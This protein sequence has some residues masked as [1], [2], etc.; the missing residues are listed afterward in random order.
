M[1]K[2]EVGLSKFI[3]FTIK[4]GPAKLSVVRSFKEQE[5]NEYSPAID[6]W[7]QLRTGIVEMHKKR[8]PFSYLDHIVDKVTDNKKSQYRTA[9]NQYKKIFQKKEIEFFHKAVLCAHSSRRS[10]PFHRAL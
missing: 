5:T 10:L 8:H 7:G 1:E 3:E 2:I 4:Q 9:I 6:Y